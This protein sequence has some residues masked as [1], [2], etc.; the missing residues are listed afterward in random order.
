MVFVIVGVDLIIVLFMLLIYCVIV[1]LFMHYILKSLAIL[2]FFY[3]SIQV[4][5]W[6]Y[7]I[8]FF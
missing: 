2:P 8:S 1:L 5:S 6:N 3:P 4:F 7:I